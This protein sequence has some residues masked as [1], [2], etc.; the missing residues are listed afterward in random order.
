MGV[1]WTPSIGLV[2][3]GEWLVSTKLTEVLDIAVIKGLQ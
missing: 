3:G 1:F 2:T